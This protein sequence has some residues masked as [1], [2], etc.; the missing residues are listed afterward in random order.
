MAIR[1]I[2]L[3]GNDILKQKTQIVEQIDN[4]I[5]E[6][7]QDMLD[8]MYKYDGIGLAASQIGILK[9]IIVYDVEYIKEDEK[10]K[11]VVFIN[12]KIIQTSKGK[13]E[14]EEGC[15]SFPDVFENVLRFE[16]VKVEYT[17]LE[18]KRKILSAKD[19]EAVVIQH[20]LDHLDGVVFLDRAKELKK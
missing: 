4:D 3:D 18:G 12:P 2:V 10:K 13:I 11:P 14:V 8:T 7:V 17:N 15:L 5:K 9:S 20:E 6:I 16:K 19:I 1:E